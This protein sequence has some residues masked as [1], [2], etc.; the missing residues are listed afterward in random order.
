M[1]VCLYMRERYER[2]GGGKGEK[3][4][5]REGGRERISISGRKAF[6]NTEMLS[7]PIHH[8]HHLAFFATLN[9]MN[10]FE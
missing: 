10:S 1:Y 2:G 5:E 3:E 9:D 4:R 7:K 8:I 6:K